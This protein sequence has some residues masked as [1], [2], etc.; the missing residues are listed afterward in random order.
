MLAKEEE[1]AK[2]AAEQE[3]NVIFEISN[4]IQKRCLIFFEK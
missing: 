4:W 3:V 2:L 1:L